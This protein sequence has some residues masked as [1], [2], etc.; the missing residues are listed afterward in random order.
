MKLTMWIIADRLKEYNPQT[1]IQSNEFEIKSVRLFTEN[2]SLS[3]G[4]LYVGKVSD[5]FENEEDY[6]I[7]AHN[8]DMIKLDCYNLEEV[9]NCILNAIEYYS[10]WNTQMLYLLTHGAMQQDL[11]DATQDL[12]PIPVFLLDAGQRLLAYTKS[13]PV[14][15][16]D[17]VWDQMLL[18]GSA[19][20]EILMDLNSKYP[21]RFNEKKMY[22][23]KTDVFPHDSFHQNF[24]LQEKWIG[25]ASLIFLDGYL[26]Q[27][28]HHHSIID[29]FTQ[30]CEYIRQWFEIHME[31]QQ[32]V[33]LDNLFRN[34]LADENYDCTDLLRQ[35]SL[36]GWNKADSYILLKLDASYQP[37]SIN[38]HLCRTLNMQYPSICAITNEFSI[39]L[40]CNL[41]LQD[42]DSL[43][44]QLLPLLEASKYYGTVSQIFTLNDSMYRQYQYVTITSGFCEKHPGKIYDGADFAMP[45]LLAEMQKTV[46]PE[47]CHP[48]LHIL[49]EYDR[50]HH[51]DFYDTLYYY[52]KNER[53]PLSTAR[54]MGLH[55]NSLAYRI[56]RLPE[57]TGADL[58][59]YMTRLHLLL[60]Y[61]ISNH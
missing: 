10:N 17:Y 56:N 51:T 5:F 22:F 14:G 61:E 44:K 20:V 41:R 32:S 9:F 49:Q 50:L 29:L 60:S 26:A 52:L 37:Y 54:E 35:L 53:S 11:F 4:T 6:I 45:Y 39:C 30:F 3:S 21:E 23:E 7:C 25:S 47:I 38:P 59:D 13:F 34:A 16:V 48:A 46:L 2:F 36:R 8:N 55:R 15:S 58:D 33:L 42:A 24:F 40:L 18:N 28:I 12:L 43:Q 31:E 57:L 27:S 19:N 1:F